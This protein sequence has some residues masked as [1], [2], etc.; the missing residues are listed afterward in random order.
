M[1][2]GTVGLG[3][4]DAM[5]HLLNLVWPNIF[6]SSPH[7]INAVMEAIEGMRCCLGQTRVLQHVL[8]GLFHPARKVREV[9]WKVCNNLYIG[10]QP[11]LVPCYPR[12]PR[13]VASSLSREI[14]YS[15]SGVGTSLTLHHDEHHHC[16]Q[17]HA[18]YS[19]APARWNLSGIQ[20]GIQSGIWIRSRHAHGLGPCRA[21]RRTGRP[22]F[23]EARD[24]PGTWAAGVGAPDRGSPKPV[25]GPHAPARR[26]RVSRFIAA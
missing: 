8:Q 20:S 16:D 10:A 13:A 17:A 7:V 21:G 1:A 25:R 6:E 15:L 18:M 2:L 12:W 4:E 11:A 9:Y 26:N 3:V 23:G 5:V 24:Q 14:K 19:G 22:D